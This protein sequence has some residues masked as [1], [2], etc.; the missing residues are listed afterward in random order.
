[1]NK[2]IQQIIMKKSAL[3]AVVAMFSGAMSFAQKTRT[4]SAGEITSNTTWYNDTVYTLD[5]YVYVKN[6]ATLT[7]QPGTLIKGNAANK[8]SLII[9]R[10]GMINAAGT[11]TA[12]IVFTS[13][14]PKGQ[15]ATGDWGGIIILGKAP[16]NRPDLTTGPSV[17]IAA[18]EPGNQ[19]AIEGDLDNANGDGL[20]GG[21]DANH[22]SGVLSYVRLEYGGVVITPGNEINGITFGGVG[23]GTQLDHIQVTHA[24]DDGFEWFGGNV[25]AKYLIS[26]RN[27]DDDLD[28]DFGFQG[29]VQFALVI[30]DSAYYDRGA[31]P[32]TNGFESDNDGAGSTNTPLTW[33][34][35]SNVTV[36]GPLANGKPL[37]GSLAGN[38][39]NNGARIRRNSATSIFNSVFM[40]WPNALFVDGNGTGNKFLTDSMGFKNNVLA[41]N[42]NAINGASASSAIVRQTIVTNG[43][44][45]SA[46]INSVYN[47]PFNYF[48]PDFGFKAGSVAAVGASFSDSKLNDIF[49]APT[50]YKGA[51]GNNNNWANGWAN[52][53]PDAADYTSPIGVVTW[54][55]AG[56]DATI[57]A[58]ATA[59]I[60][61]LATGGSGRFAYTWFPTTGLNNA[62]IAR[63]IASPTTTT[64]YYVSLLDSNSGN[65]WIDT[66]TVN[67]NPTPAANFTF[68]ANAGT[69]SFTNASTNATSNLWNFGDGD[70]SIVE[71]PNHTF[72]ANG[73]FNVRLNA[74]NGSCNNTATRLVQIT[75]INSPVKNV[76]AGDIT[77]NTTWHSDTIYELGGYVYVKNN[78]TLTIQPGT[79]VKGGVSANKGC[80]IITRNGMINAAGTK[81]RPIIFTS[82]KPKGQRATGDWGG[83]IILGKAPINR[84]DLTTGPSVAIAANEPGNQ[85]AIEGDL[86]NANGDGLYGGTDANHN[87]GVLSY[88]RLEFGGVVITPGNEINGITFGG[89]GKATQVDHVQ[90]TQ[91]ND[92]G[93]EWFG[94][95]VNAKYIISHRNIDDDLDVDFGFQGKVQFALVIRDSA[96]YDRG[97]GPTTNGFESDN[98]GAGSN[99]TPLTWPVFSN[100]TVMGPLANGKPLTGSL[101]GNSF[102]NGARIRRNSA[103]SIFNSVFMGWPNALFVDGNG[104]GNKFATDSMGFKNNV[105]AGNINAINGASANAAIVRQTIVTN[106]TDTSATIDAVYNNPFNYFNP[107][108]GFKAGSLAASGA[109][110]SDNKLSDAF[111]TQTTYKGAFGNNNKWADCWANFNPET[112]DYNAGPYV[113]N[114]AVAAFNASENNLAVTFTNGS[115]G[116]QMRFEWNFGVASSTNDTSTLQNPTYT[117]AEKGDYLVTLKVM[118]PCG[119]STITKTIAVVGKVGI[120]E[121]Q[122]VNN[123]S[124]YP[125]PTSDVTNVSF[126]LT[127]NTN[128]SIN[129]FDISGRVVKTI[130]AQFL[131]SGNKTITMQTSDVNAGVYFANIST[132]KFS[133]T[134]RLVIIK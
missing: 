103:T 117:Y 109:S 121:V 39:F 84:P 80:I 55:G 73:V 68:I 90:V 32:T 91:A 94:G 76:A 28:V 110:F 31:G 81:N 26:H 36:M 5:G 79:I 130:P 102:N 98:D 59:T 45:T 74:I 95:N 122:N 87:S 24:N 86:D 38:S 25:N 126:D 10:N 2:I 56:N 75:G 18:N 58:G 72:R 78:A 107:D 54:T 120:N 35:F 131:T 11:A 125:N 111:F 65:T 7:I 15:R 123:V 83:I 22:S 34:V 66:I 51:F 89:V 133:K 71:N 62:N 114:A 104:T 41:G 17:A 43:T 60:G 20:Y 134:Y 112:E 97:A 4:I 27:I 16:I 30:R 108:F 69:V 3:L 8:A 119:D 70:T 100:V 106:G 88:V 129:L 82:S 128:V 6:N 61:T 23:K 118:S 12:P 57:C 47:D 52:F 21:I 85:V 49:F 113:Q 37:T 132:D 63:P 105:L 1:L 9:T 64:T 93:F 48:N 53:N 13:S 99:N 50:T 92:D 67:V 124:L 127:E 96:Y 116:K 29:K 46:A 19:V 33:P 44:D 77:E 115:I 101:A 40:G 42:I 14:K